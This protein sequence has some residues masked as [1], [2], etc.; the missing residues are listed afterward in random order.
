[1]EASRTTAHERFWLSSDIHDVNLVKVWM[2][3]CL[4]FFLFS[5]NA[6]FVYNL[7]ATL[8]YGLQMQTQFAGR[9]RNENSKSW[10]PN[11]KYNKGKGKE[12]NPKNETDGNKK[13]DSKNAGWK[14]TNRRRVAERTDKDGQYKVKHDMSRC[15]LTVTIN[16]KHD[17]LSFKC[18]TWLWKSKTID[19]RNT[20]LLVHTVCA[21]GAQ[22]N[23]K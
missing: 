7:T 23:L 16:L 21:P 1:M 18:K 8:R 17:I 10:I 6:K 19:S 2:I 14:R 5:F 20:F 13:R 12:E 11:P 9:L 15:D 3:R 22:I 4:T